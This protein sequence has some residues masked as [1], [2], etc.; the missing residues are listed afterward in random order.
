M[1]A[2]T[3]VIAPPRGRR[4]PEP[5]S[6]ERQRHLEAVGGRVA[7]RS[8]PRLFY[9]M[10]AVTTVFLIVVTQLL[11]SVGVSQG[12]Y[13]IESLQTSK[14]SLA[15]NLQAATEKVDT[16]SSPQNLAAK[17]SALGMIDGNSPAYLRL[18]NG[19][20]AGAP[21]AAT[22]SPA[23]SGTVLVPNALLAKPK[24]KASTPAKKATPEANEQGTQHSPVAWDGALPSPSTH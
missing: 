17:A 23:P 11:L 13:R 21:V 19:T 5:D 20:V 6:G 1:S 16:L 18:S 9:A 14:T 24:P 4:A 3:A 10:A 12:A 22:G 8:R 2:T 15:R 7:R